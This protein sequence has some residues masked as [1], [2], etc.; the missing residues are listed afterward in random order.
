MCD[1]GT[2]LGWHQDGTAAGQTMLTSPTFK[3]H[4]HSAAWRPKASRDSTTQTFVATIQARIAGLLWLALRRAARVESTADLALSAR[5]ASRHALSEQRMI[6][7]HTRMT[8]CATASVRGAECMF[9][10]SGAHSVG[11][12]RVY[13]RDSSSP[14]LLVLARTSWLSVPIFLHSQSNL[15]TSDLH[16]AQ[17]R[18]AS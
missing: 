16:F 18:Q 17:R 14:A 9:T 5:A 10:A 13:S 2:G 4:G 7:S 6:C 3:Q 15:L 12:L 8:R 1:I 11:R